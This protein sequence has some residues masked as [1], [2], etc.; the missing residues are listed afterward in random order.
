MQDWSGQNNWICPLE[1]LIIDS[2]RHLQSCAGMGTLI[3]LECPSS[4]L[5]G[6]GHAILGNFV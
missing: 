2:V 6:L 5:K 1:N 3:M 4:Y